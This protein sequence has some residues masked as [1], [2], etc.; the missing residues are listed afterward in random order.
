[1]REANLK[2]LSISTH[3]YTMPPTLEA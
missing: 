1:M 2:R 3:K